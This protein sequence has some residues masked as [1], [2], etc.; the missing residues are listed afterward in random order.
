[1]L[2]DRAVACLSAVAVLRFLQYYT[3]AQ[4]S[5]ATIGG[6]VSDTGG[7]VIAHAKV[8]VTNLETGIDTILETNESGSYVA[9]LLIPGNYRVTAEHPGFKRFSRTGITL[10]VNDNLQIDIKLDIG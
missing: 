9:P 3:S 8:I 6:Q 10:S 4:E 1:M 5:R 2:L 7:A